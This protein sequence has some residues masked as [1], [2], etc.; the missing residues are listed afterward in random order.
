MNER[1]NDHVHKEKA[2]KGDGVKKRKIR[3]SKVREERI[4]SLHAEPFIEKI[5]TD[6][7]IAISDR[8]ASDTTWQNSE[9]IKSGS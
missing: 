9:P 3:K 4:S 1:I 2:K 5:D 7:L 8:T 6:Q